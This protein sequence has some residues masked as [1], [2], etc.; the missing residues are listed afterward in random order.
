MIACQKLKKLFADIL[1]EINSNSAVI[2][3]AVLYP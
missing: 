2:I 3:I 1:S